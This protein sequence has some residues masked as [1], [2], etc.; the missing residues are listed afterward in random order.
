VKIKSSLEMGKKVFGMVLLIR[1]FLIFVFCFQVSSLEAKDVY[2]IDLE[3]ILSIG[4]LDD[5][6]IFQWVGV[7]V[8]LQKQIY[9][10]DAM[11]YSLKKFD[12]QGKLLKK[13]G[14][15]GQ[16]PGEFL[17][18]RFLDSSEKYLYVIDQ[19]LPGIQVFNK[20]LEFIFR[21]PLKLP[22][23]DFK[24]LS[25]D[26]IAVASLLSNRSGAIYI[27]DAEGEVIR[28]IQ[29]T[30][31]K[32]PFMMDLVSFDIGVSG[33]LYLAYTFQDKVEKFD[34]QGKKLWSQKL[35]KVNK[36]ERKKV[37]RFVVPT[38]IVYKDVALDRSERLY[39]LGGSFSKNKGRD[40]YVLSPEGELLTII[41]LPEASHCIYLDSQDF[42]YARANEG[43]TLKKYK[44]HFVYDSK[45]S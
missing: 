19:N 36:V 20:N 18:P 3:E 32:S 9:V 6:A 2:K 4:T 43:I 29:F 24:V 38:E 17:A 23:V 8:D 5:D 34:A 16:G 10:S 1:T 15:R 7:S 14:R 25:D 42:L 21:L 33:H 39:I 44:L 40:V 13:T 41:T 28:S 12:P 27:I 37:S 11:D 30:D 45:G 31:K 22:V 35:L 26:E